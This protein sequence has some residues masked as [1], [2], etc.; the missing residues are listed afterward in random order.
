MRDYLRIPSKN[1]K[2]QL[3]KLYT[4]SSRVQRD[5]L[6]LSNSSFYESRLIFYPQS[7]WKSLFHRLNNLLTF[8]QKADLSS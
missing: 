8:D 3:E 5:E 1:N 6:V 7:S 2:N 4:R